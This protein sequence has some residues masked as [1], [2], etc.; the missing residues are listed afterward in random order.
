[1]TE[2][3]IW[4]NQEISRLRKDMQRTFRRFCECYG[5][6]FSSIE[7]VETFDFEMLETD[8]KLVFTARIPGLK[9]ENLNISVTEM[10]LLLK[11]EIQETVFET[12]ASHQR[13]SH[14]AGTFSRSFVLP[15]RV[16]VDEVEAVYEDDRLRIVMPKAKTKK[17]DRIQIE[18]R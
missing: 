10:Q 7:A 18:V 9:T 11:G 8:D 5:V 16:N 12:T 14:R 13:V 2:L 6:P 3:S 4:K 1:M 17:L 15:F